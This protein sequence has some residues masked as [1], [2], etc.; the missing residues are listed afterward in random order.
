MCPSHI[1]QKQQILRSTSWTGGQ[2]RSAWCNPSWEIL[3]KEARSFPCE[4]IQLTCI[5]AHSWRKA[6]KARSQVREMY[7]CGILTGAKGVQM[8]QPLYSEGSCE[9][10]CSLWRIDV[11]VCT[12]VDSSWTIF[13][14][15]WQHKRQSTKVNYTWL[16]S[17]VNQIERTTILASKR[18][19]HFLA[20][21]ND[22]ERKGKNV[23]VWR[24]SIRRQEINS[25]TQ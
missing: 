5:R 7:P 23:G 21:S 18:S 24:C 10:G 20:K 6:A 22:G 14:W 11:M 19:K 1:G 3:W 17:N 16:E 8:L 15:P 13:N 9:L 25:F 4:D 12:W 2:H